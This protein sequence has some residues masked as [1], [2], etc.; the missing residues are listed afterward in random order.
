MK[1]LLTFVLVIGSASCFA[2]ETEL[3]DLNLNNIRSEL[4]KEV[5]SGQTNKNP[6]GTTTILGPR[7]I[8]GNRS[9]PFAASTNL[10]GVCKAM[11]FKDYL[12]QSV[13]TLRDISA[14][15]A[16]VTPEGIYSVIKDI[17]YNSINEI[18]CFNDEYKTYTS[19]DRYIENS[20]DTITVLKPKL[21]RGNR[22]YPFAATTN[23][24]G[25]CRAMGFKNHLAQSVFTIRDKTAQRAYVTPEGAYAVIKDIE[26]ESINEIT[27]IHGNN[28]TT[29]VIDAQGGLYFRRNNF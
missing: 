27:C 17:E 13:F 19:L 9:Y 5:T 16:Y 29:V 23:L 10:G 12:A 25:V 4:P 2:L 11:G 1:N 20:D 22:S 21:V 6:D 28:N 3:M 26:Y 15:R 7:L 14:Q 24:N 18:T 8:R